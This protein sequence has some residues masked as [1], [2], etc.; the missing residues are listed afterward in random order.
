[1]AKAKRAGGGAAL[2]RVTRANRIALFIALGIVASAVL[3]F[4]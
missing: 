4:H 3:A 1:V 2:A